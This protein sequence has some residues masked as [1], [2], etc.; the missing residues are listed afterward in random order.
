MDN[1]KLP[2]FASA[3]LLHIL[4]LF[5]LELVAKKTFTCKPFSYMEVVHQEIFV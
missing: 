4:F 5:I 2:N 1:I 3:C